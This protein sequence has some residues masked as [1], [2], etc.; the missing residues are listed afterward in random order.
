MNKNILKKYVK[1]Y[2][3]F[4]A[5]LI[6]SLNLGACHDLDI[7]NPNDPTFDNPPDVQKLVTGI[8]HGMRVDLPIYFQVVGTF[9]REVYYLEPAD[10]RYTG[11]LLTGPID[12]G[13][14]L[15]NRPWA[16]RYRTINTANEL[17]KQADTGD[18]GFANTIIAYQLLLNLNLL[19]ENGIKIVFSDDVSTPF[20]SKAEAFAE[21]ER[22]L[23]DANNDLTTA[24]NDGDDFGFALSGGFAGF[25]QPS[26]FAQINRALKARVAVYQQKWQEALDALAG[27]FLDPAQPLDV[28]V[29]HVYSTNSG[30]MTNGIWENPSAESHRLVAHPSFQTNAEPDDMRFAKK[31]LERDEAILFDNLT[32]KWAVTLYESATSPVPIIRNEELIL[33]RAEANIGLNNLAEANNDINVVRQAAG[34]G[35]IDLAAMTPEQAVDQLLHERHYSLFA[36]GHRWL[37]VRRY[38]K[39]AEL[40]LDRQGDVIIEKMVR[41]ES[42][43]KEGN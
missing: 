37:D 14:F 25:D 29:Y 18:R 35:N 16:G 38:N 27:S 32:S 5:L 2:S 39:L 40:P 26:T 31:V 9:G 7:A 19:D 3:I 6:F 12:A 33:I 10:P 30:D 41:P 17:L 8:E 15:L 11:E 36:E 21:I 23:D 34:L 4:F 43:V 28:G 20:V 42:E 13:G 1:M 24:A 22:L